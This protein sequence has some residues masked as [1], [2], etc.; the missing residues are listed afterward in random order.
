MRRSSKQGLVSGYQYGTP[1]EE[2]YIFFGQSD[3]WTLGPWSSDAEFLY[4]GR[5]VDRVREVL[6]CCN[7]TYVEADGQKLVS[8]PRQIL[9]CEIISAGKQADVFSSDRDA[10]VSQEALHNVSAELE[11]VLTSGL[12]GSG[13]TGL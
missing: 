9:R 2:H 10:M 11:P 8:C 13:K 6:I 3:A 7:G 12:P 1:E 4:W 5:G